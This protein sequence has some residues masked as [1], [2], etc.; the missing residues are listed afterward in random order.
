MGILKV[1]M[2]I[3]RDNEWKG[4]SMVF[5]ELWIRYFL[6]FYMC[7]MVDVEDLVK[8]KNLVDKVFGFMEFIF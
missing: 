8:K 6:N 5:V 1:F 2:R 7:I 3:R 4:I